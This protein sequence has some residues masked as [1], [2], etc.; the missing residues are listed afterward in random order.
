MKRVLA[1]V[2]LAGL[3]G[4]GCTGSAGSSGPGAGGRARR[5]GRRWRNRPGRRVGQRW[6]APAAPDPS[7]AGGANSGSGGTTGAG[8]TGAG[9]GGGMTTTG[10]TGGATGSGGSITGGGGAVSIGA[11]YFIGADITDQE[12][13]A[14]RD[15]RQLAD[16]D[17]GARVQ[18]RPLADLRRSEGRRRLRQDQ[19][20][21]RHRSHGRVRQAGQGRG[22]GSARRLSLQRQLGRSRQAMR[23]GRLAE[24]HDNRRPCDR[25]PR[26]HQ[27]R[28]HAAGGGRRAPR[29]G[30]D[31]ERRNA[32]PPDSPVRQPWVAARGHRRLQR[33]ERR[34][35]SLF[36]D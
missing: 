5:L 24:H 34:A 12:T 22:H 35:L 36:V 6:P 18:L 14:G 20:Q 10:G 31:R 25:R 29:H 21:R 17:E 8:G 13:A 3:S 28:Y 2:L 7:G 30:S 15:A 16:P 32:G 19:R 4:S 1:L 33:R 23:P 26:L 27:G 11:S 9:G